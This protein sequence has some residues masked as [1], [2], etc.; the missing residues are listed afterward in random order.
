MSM[1]DL[2]SI[3]SSYVE[4]GEGRASN[5]VNENGFTAPIVG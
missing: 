4:I 1:E 5:D 2:G 3:G